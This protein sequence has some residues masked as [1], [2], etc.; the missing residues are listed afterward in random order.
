MLTKN[1]VSKHEWKKYICGTVKKYKFL[2]TP[3]IPLSSFMDRH[4]QKM[5]KKDSFCRKMMQLGKSIHFSFNQMYRNE[6]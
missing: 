2:F 6:L 3:G 5:S 1:I 4:G